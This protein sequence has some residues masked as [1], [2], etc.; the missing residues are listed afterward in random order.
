MTG[1]LGICLYYIGCVLQLSRTG[2]LKLNQQL[3]LLFNM[4]HISESKCWF[5]LFNYVWIAGTR[6]CDDGG[7]VWGGGGW[8]GGVFPSG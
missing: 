2:K 5:V 8:G 6:S 4:C 7:A 3:N 1:K